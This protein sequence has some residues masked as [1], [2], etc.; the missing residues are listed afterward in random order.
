MKQKTIRTVGVLGF[1]L[2]LMLYGHRVLAD[3]FTFDGGGKTEGQFVGAGIPIEVRFEEDSG[4][5]KIEVV[6]YNN[7]KAQ[8]RLEIWDEPGHRVVSFNSGSGI[9]YVQLTELRTGSATVHVIQ[10]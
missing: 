2:L 10:N 8:R 1:F 5:N 6:L 7:Q 3:T 4:S 9:C